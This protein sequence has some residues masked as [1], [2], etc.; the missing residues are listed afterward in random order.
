MEV[1]VGG[2]P[3]ER[4]AQTDRAPVERA[5]CWVARLRAPGS[6]VSTGR[7]C[8]GTQ[9]GRG[10]TLIDELGLAAHGHHAHRHGCVT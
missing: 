3:D 4:G 10:A 8:S 6:T 9:S 1:G 2:P 5:W 7:V